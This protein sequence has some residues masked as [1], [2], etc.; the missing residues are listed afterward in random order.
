MR[1]VLCLFAFSSVLCATTCTDSTCRSF[2][3]S[4]GLL[5]AEN[6][7]RGTDGEAASWVSDGFL[8]LVSACPTEALGFLSKRQDVLKN[9]LRNIEDL[10]GFAVYE[11]EAKIRLEALRSLRLRLKQAKVSDGEIPVQKLLLS[12]I[13]SVCIRIVDTEDKLCVSKPR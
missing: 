13:N 9:W 7:Q 3:T 10:S 1:Y 6:Q 11:Q 8:L 12:K 5:L 4:L 2:G